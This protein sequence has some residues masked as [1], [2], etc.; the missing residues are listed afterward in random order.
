[1][2]EPEGGRS[3]RVLVVEDDP[4]TAQVLFEVL[5]GFGHTVRVVHDGAEGLPALLRD[6]PDLL[7]VDL[8][9]PGLDGVEL[10]E[11]ARAA[12]SLAGLK[13]IVLSGKIY[14]AD[15]A[16]ALGA[17]ADAFLTKPVRM[18]VLSETIARVMS[19]GAVVRFW[20]VRGTLPAPARSNVRYG[21]NTSC[22]SLHMPQDRF[23]V[24][25]AGTGIRVLG[26]Q[27]LAE[28]PARLTGTVLITHPHW[29][30]IN[31]LP[32]FG[33]LYVPG[34]Q[35]EVCGPAQGR[36]GMKELVAAQMDGRFFPI[37]PRE[38]GADVHY[39]DLRPGRCEVQGLQV[40]CILLMHPGTCLGYRVYHQGRSIAYITDQELVPEDQ[41]WSSP[42]LRERLVSALAGVDLLIA[43]CTYT[44]E[45][46]PKRVGWGHSAVG[47]TV[48]LAHDAGAR[49]LA[50]F[51]H[52]P[53][54]TDDDIDAKLAFAQA[55]LLS[56]GSTTRV[57]APAEGDALPL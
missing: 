15:R 19:G 9:M 46:Y 45:E 29:D 37:T 25:D 52:D 36:M 17:G 35:V 21:G 1:M 34:N 20:G 48:D 12:A 14:D 31:A 51:H 49:T 41:P 38:F 10:C 30:H 27:L 18:A 43:D 23:I 42:E 50:L 44:D 2:S 3:L 6:P 28:G 39:R 55:R 11:Q 13:I 24:F 26:A 57:I 32:F 33:P 8:M 22:V 53:S 5:S 56:L 7:L 16:A 47:A 4:A 40:E 54:Q